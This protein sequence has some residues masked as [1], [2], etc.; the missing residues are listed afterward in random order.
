[1]ANDFKKRVYIEDSCE[2]DQMI[3]EEILRQRDQAIE[4]LKKMTVHRLIIPPP[5]WLEKESSARIRVID[6][7]G[8]SNQ[9]AEEAQ[10][11]LE[12]NNLLEK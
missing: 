7:I 9:L 8:D 5:E 1:M 10:Q 12:K 4:L 2:G 3:F 11:F 6:F